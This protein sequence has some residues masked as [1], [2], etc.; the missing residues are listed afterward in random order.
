MTFSNEQKEKLAAPLSRE[1]VK[2]RKQGN[3]PVSYIEAWHAIAEA[4][5]VF[6][7][8]GWTRETVHMACVV[9]Q[10][11]KIGVTDTFAGYD[12]WGVSYTCRVRVSAGGVV[13]EGSGSGHGIDRDIGQAHESAVKEAE[14]DAMKRALMTFGNPFGLALYDK[15]QANVSDDEPEPPQ[16]QRRETEA[17]IAARLEFIEGGNGTIE[18]LGGNFPKLVAWFQ[19][20]EQRDARQ[21]YQISVGEFEMMKAKVIAKRPPGATS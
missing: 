16:P 5:R 10:E 19:S 21:K 20:Q 11:R 18:E 4:N 14:S 8:D 1:V 3:R 12:G 2:S 13:R 9:E 15:T 17:Q 7:F 6:G